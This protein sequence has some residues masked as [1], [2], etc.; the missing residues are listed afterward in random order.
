MTSL[1]HRGLPVRY[2]R[3]ESLLAQRRR[4]GSYRVLASGPSGSAAAGVGPGEADCGIARD[5]D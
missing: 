4:A 5:I 3:P 2:L 1:I